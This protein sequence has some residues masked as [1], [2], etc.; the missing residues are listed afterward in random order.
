MLRKFLSRLIRD[1]EHG[2]PRLGVAVGAVIALAVAIVFAFTNLGYA[3]RLDLAALDVKFNWRSP[4]EPSDRILQVDIDDISIQMLG[5]FP[6]PRDEHAKLIRALDDLGAR[7]VVFDIEF[8]DA[9]PSS[10][11][12][13]AAG[14]RFDPET[15]APL[16]R[17]RDLYLQ[18]AMLYSGNVLSAYSFDVE[19]A[20]QLGPELRENYALL[21]KILEEDL[22]QDAS[23]I[24]EASGVPVELVAR[25]VETLRTAV[26]D[27][28]VSEAFAADPSI[29]LKAVR[30]KLLGE[31]DSGAPLWLVRIMRSSLN[32]FRSAEGIRLRR[33][34]I[35]VD[36][37]A[38][39]G[40]RAF[41]IR[42]PYLPF[43]QSVRDVGSAHS[44][45]DI[46]GVI[47]RVPLYVF[48][49]GV[50]YLYMGLEAGL[51][52]LET[53]DLEAHARIRPGEVVVEVRK[54]SG[55]EIV[56]TVC[57]P[58]DA[59]GRALVFWTDPDR[60]SPERHIKYANFID[61]YEKRIGIP[62]RN[63]RK[64]IT[65]LPGGQ[66]SEHHRE[67]LEVS[68]KLHRAYGDEEVE[69]AGCTEEPA[70][71]GEVRALAVR[72]KELQHR[73]VEDLKSDIAEID[74]A[75][76]DGRLQDRL[77]KRMEEL[78]AKLDGMRRDVLESHTLETKLRP[79]VE[80][81]VCIVGSASTA[82]GDLHP[83]P[84]DPNTPGPD[85]HTNI[86]NMV[87]TGQVLTEASGFVNFLYI[88][89]IGALV[90][91]SIAYLH[92]RTAILALVGVLAAHVG[93]VML[94]FSGA[95]YEISGA[96]P[97]VAAV[98]AFA[99]GMTFKELVT[100]R[101]Q[102]KL[103]KELTVHTSPEMVSLVM[104]DPDL[105]AKPRRIR[106]SIFFSDVKGFTSLTEGMKEEDLTVLVNRYLDRMSSVL[107]EQSA[108]VDKYIGDGIMALFGVPVESGDH[109]VQACMA[110][111][112]AQEALAALNRELAA[113]EMPELGMR[114]GI[115]SGDVVAAYFGS[116]DRSDY[117]VM[118]DSVN[119][120]ARLEGANK[121]YGT[122][123]MVSE[124]TRGL[125]G[126]LFVYRELDNIRV[127]GKKKPTRVFELVGHA[128]SPV[129]FP[130]GFLPLY[131]EGMALFHGRK[132]EEARDR[133]EEARKLCPDDAPVSMYVG[134]CE[135]F[136]MSPPPPEWE[137][138]F[139]LKEK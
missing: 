118:G 90:S 20:N 115:N 100:R 128:G 47:R 26:L 79:Y 110:A 71:P 9:S 117:T 16:A 63:I 17:G 49:R 41:D 94:T 82:S 137:G 124:S 53:E 84:L 43:L 123:I 106:A 42:P 72:R 22:V 40:R 120:A 52:A 112:H 97:A 56:R 34:A 12:A 77:K 104:R 28:L 32:K 13:G 95:R 50:P 80:G 1:A 131:E 10:F 46:D 23:A 88:L 76:A 65:D 111:L 86:V 33:T 57:L 14:A 81:K 138:V 59:A 105:I 75:L 51:R 125:A 107:K 109:A 78:R 58:T 68:T 113:E 7:M 130:D 64:L 89:F 55:G 96:G 66:R 60:G 4:A 25:E 2:D 29:T 67:Y 85:A 108:Y 136:M 101:S 39:G 129:G 126:D 35:R 11:A 24:S 5:K 139:E 8:H 74:R 19:G 18:R 36:E 6:F 135:A 93:I 48:W 98:L 45:K 102:R 83:T 127:V 114:I 69:G 37:T 31:K 15:G 91:F 103:Q 87:L 62:D 54:R 30:A 99:S 133:F 116:S 70:A 119:L 61:Y 27:D 73:I 21:R 134:R 38:S 92:E 132:F 121:Q 3:H 44:G 122:A